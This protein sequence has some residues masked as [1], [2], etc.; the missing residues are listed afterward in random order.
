MD[1]DQSNHCD[2]DCGGTSNA[3]R[4]KFICGN[5]QIYAHEQD[6]G[7]E[8]YAYWGSIARELDNYPR[9]DE[10]SKPNNKASMAPPTPTD[11]PPP[12][13]ID[14]AAHKATC[15]RGATLAKPAMIP[16][17]KLARRDQL[18]PMRHLSKLSPT[19]R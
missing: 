18:R 4:G 6:C 14:D 19:P 5:R 2:N 16:G 12:T 7:G 17:D 13:P 15:S 1:D 11:T 3:Y 8:S 10:H 9:P